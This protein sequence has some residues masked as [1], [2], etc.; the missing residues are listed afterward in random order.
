MQPLDVRAITPDDWSAWRTIRLRALA[1]APDS[2][3]SR[4][5]EVDDREPTWRARIEAAEACYLAF[6]GDA[7]VGMV[8]ADPVSDGIALQSMFVVDEARGRGVGPRLIDAVVTVAGRRQLVLGVMAANAPAIRA[9]ERAGFL[10]DDKVSGV[11][12]ELTMRFVR[13]RAEE[14]DHAR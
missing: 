11:D 9:Y 14:K 8:A 4:L 12:C 1:E 5:D 13:R 7:V 3:G 2:F 6:A 10:H